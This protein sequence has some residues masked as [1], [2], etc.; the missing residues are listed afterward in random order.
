ML[1]LSMTDKLRFLS[2]A[3]KYNVEIIDYRAGF[4]KLIIKEWF[5]YEETGH[6][7]LDLLRSKAY[8]Y[9]IEQN[10]TVFEISYDPRM[11]ASSETLQELSTLILKHAWI[12]N[13][14]SSLC[15]SAHFIEVDMPCLIEQLLLKSPSY[16][17]FISQYIQEYNTLDYFFLDS[18]RSIHPFP[19]FKKVDVNLTSVSLYFIFLNSL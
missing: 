7:L 13:L 17:L 5:A 1:L 14:Q 15:R 6:Y 9:R 3:S 19:F 4:V 11:E 2:L 12:R 8:I 16:T 18:I 10:E